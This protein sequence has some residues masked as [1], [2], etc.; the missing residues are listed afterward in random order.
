M[1]D[2]QSSG[3]LSLGS[4]ARPNTPFADP[5][6]ELVQDNTEYAT[7]TK[8]PALLLWIPEDYTS[9]RNHSHPT[10]PQ[11]SYK[12]RL[13]KQ[14]TLPNLPPL[15]EESSLSSNE[16]K[17][18][19][20]E[21]KKQENGSSG[22]KMDTTSKGFKKLK[23]ASQTTKESGQNS[24]TI[25]NCSKNVV[26][27]PKIDTYC[28]SYVRPS[29]NHGFAYAVSSTELLSGK[30]ATSRKAKRRKS[31]TKFNTTP[32]NGFSHHSNMYLLFR[33]PSRACGLNV[34]A[35]TVRARPKELHHLKGAQQLVKKAKTV[36]TNIVRLPDINED[37]WK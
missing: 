27:L 3:E 20:N 36:Q 13:T 37:M 29:T 17:E 12:Y 35:L 33:A 25:E 7:T 23:N 9:A 26:A 24:F 6:A 16:R 1:D 10:K 5:M 19:K 14:K 32:E 22:Q 4:E 30:N 31:T 11:L 28:I 15:T 8:D 18:N 2:D 34:P 21:I